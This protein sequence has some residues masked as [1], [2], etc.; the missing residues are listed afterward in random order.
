[1]T[2]FMHVE[3]SDTFQSI[4]HRAAGLLDPKQDESRVGL[5]SATDKAKQLADLATIADQE[6]QNDQILYVLVQSGG[7]WEEFDVPTSPVGEEK[8]AH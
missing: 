6:I 7:V 1:M 3:P 4:K 2:I 5:F 8:D